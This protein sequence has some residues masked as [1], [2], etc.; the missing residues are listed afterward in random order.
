M[1]Y[2]VQNKRCPYRPMLVW[3]LGLG[4]VAGVGWLVARLLDKNIT[5]TTSAVATDGHTCE[6]VIPRYVQKA[7]RAFDT[8]W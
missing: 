6:D 8:W 1:V 7:A 4:T 2:I 5:T 3:G